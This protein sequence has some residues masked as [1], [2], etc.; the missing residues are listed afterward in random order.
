MSSVNSFRARHATTAYA[1]GAITWDTST[2]LDNESFTANMAEIKDI[3]V[4]PPELSYEKIDCIGNTQQTVGANSQVRGTATGV[5][6]G[7]FQNQAVQINSA[8]MW[9]I[10]GTLVVTGEEQGPDL[11]ALDTA[12][13]ITGGYSRYSISALTSTGAWDRTTIGSMRVYLNN[14]SE[15]NCIVMSNVYVKLGDLKPTGTDG[16]WERDIE[17]MCLAKDGAFEW[18]D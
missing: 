15:E 16:H 18:K 12:A 5:V 6:A 1:T 13:S 4:T 17:I 14:G 11:L 9:M 3:T 7:Y 8:G 10:S 2:P